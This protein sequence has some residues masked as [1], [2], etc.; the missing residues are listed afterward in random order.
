MSRDFKCWVILTICLTFICVS[1]ALE[2]LS[3]RRVLSR[4]RRQ[5]HLA[6]DLSSSADVAISG[7]PSIPPDYV[8]V[9]PEVGSDIY[10]GTIVSLVPIVYA[11][12][13]FTSRIRVQRACLVCTGSGLTYVT[14]KGTTLSRPRKCWSCG[15]FIPWLGWK[16][17]F[18]STF[19]DPGNGGVLQRP[20][21][22]YEATNQ[23]IRETQEQ[24]EQSSTEDLSDD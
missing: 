9:P 14:R 10:V 11:T 8:F 4:L 20:A 21:K 1:D 23:R 15:G 7:L 3:S 6:S 2:A 19:T 12:Y 17:F 22:D 16:M 13:E 18:L 5:Q 24:Q